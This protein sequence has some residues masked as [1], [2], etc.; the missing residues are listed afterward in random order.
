[1]KAKSW[2]RFHRSRLQGLLIKDL[3][4]F[5]EKGKKGSREQF[6]Q[7]E[8]Y[9]PR[10]Q[11]KVFGILGGGQQCGVAGAESTHQ[12]VEG[13]KDGKANWD[14]IGQKYGLHPE[15]NRETLP[16]RTFF[17]TNSCGTIHIQ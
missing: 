16:C 2:G 7:S 6:R 5:V 12:E 4:D 11:N 13:K 14:Q 15:G 17:L 8:E 1:M 10:Q 9:E 3:F